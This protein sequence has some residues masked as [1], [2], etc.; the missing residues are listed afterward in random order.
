MKESCNNCR[1]AVNCPHAQDG[2]KCPAYAPELT[3]GGCLFW[4]CVLILVSVYIA[5]HIKGGM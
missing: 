2:E 3:L 4:G 1:F 5:Y